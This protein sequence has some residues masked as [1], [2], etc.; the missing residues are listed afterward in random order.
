MF[1]THN[2]NAN[3]WD[4]LVGFGAFVLVFWNAARLGIWEPWEA[5][6]AAIVR[7]MLESGNLLAVNVG[8]VQQPELL[9][10]LPFGW[11]PHVATYWVLG[12]SELALRLPNVFWCSAVCV[13]VYWV[14]QQL[15]DRRIARLSLLIALST[16]LIAF[17]GS[18]ALG[19][20]AAQ[21]STSL[22][23]LWI[24]GSQ[25]SGWQKRR[26]RY[27]FWLLILTASLISGIIGLILPIAVLASCGA[28]QKLHFTSL[29]PHLPLFLAT[30]A[31]LIGGWAWA[32]A[33]SPTELPTIQWL[34][35]I[36]GL[37]IDRR[38]GFHPAF[39]LYVHQIGFGLF[40]WGVLAPIAFGLMAFGR[41]SV[42]HHRQ[43]QTAIFVWFAGA[44]AYG[45][46]TFS[47]THYA[48]FLAAPAL[49]LALAPLFV[50]LFEDRTS[51]GFLVITAVLFVALLDSNLK[52][53]PRALAETFVGADVETFPAAVAYTKWGRMLD[54]ALLGILIV[55][56][57]R[58]QTWL[59]ALV[60]RIWYP[61][62]Q[63]KF[64]SPLQVLI[65]TSLAIIAST[66]MQRPILRLAQRLTLGGLMNWAK[67]VLFGTLIG[68]VFHA[69]V[70]LIW[71][72]RYRRG[73]RHAQP[74]SLP[75]FS[76]NAH[77]AVGGVMLV[78]FGWVCLQQIIVTSTLT[79]NFSQRAL[80]GKYEAHRSAL[81]DAP[82]YTLGLTTRDRSYYAKDLDKLNQSKFSELCRNN[83]P[84]FAIIP[85]KDLAK[86]NERFRNSVPK[87]GAGTTK[88]L[89]VLYDG[90]ARYY[91][92]AN[93][94]P[95]GAT[96]LNPMKRALLSDESELPADVNRVDINFENKVKIIGWR[97]EPKVA[98][99]GSPLKM[100]VYWKV[101][102]NR[103]GSWKVFVHI[104]APGQRLH[105]DHDPVAG[106]L[107]TENWRVG[108]IIADEHTIKVD[109]TKSPAPYTFYTGLFRGK[110]RL[111]VTDGPQDGKN[112][113]KLGRILLK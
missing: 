93:Q 5:E 39:S 84:F 46:I 77:L 50:R 103:I 100:I 44:F 28:F 63:P 34:W 3:L 19:S 94:L 97:T 99:R 96:D 24:L 95:R 110:N 38:A 36:D 111:K 102:K 2:P 43:M 33:F 68:L 85:Q 40:P 62:V 89:P 13:A 4:I 27:G 105:G 66:A 41:K 86:V 45:A 74:L 75:Q 31:L 18:L 109:R 51:N 76:A 69:I 23:C 37:A 26:H 56:A 48:L 98:R 17:N 104:D 29:Q 54:F 21:A 58:I 65:S 15:F 67:L 8:S 12:E 73:L 42:G 113:A 72:W 30:I 107:P 70:H 32:N 57:T 92:V 7:N 71:R 101:L 11:W 79:N 64:W 112:R 78:M 53:D 22:A 81:Q 1:R 10:N 88:H 35:F 83:E 47:W 59:E 20:M 6:A 60:T 80:L 14:A 91:L 108:D 49:A 52:H 25:A 61:S 90:G 87:S 55:F 82:L 16:P 9:S 106:L